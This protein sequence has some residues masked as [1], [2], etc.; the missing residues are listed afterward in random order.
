[1]ERGILRFVRAFGMLCAAALLLGAVGCGDDGECLVRGE[2]CT[3][4]YKLN[5]YGT[6]NIDCCEG[7][8]HYGPVSGV[9]ICGS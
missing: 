4:Q 1:M 5:N 9:L 6:E 3:S 8:C 7:G 2:N